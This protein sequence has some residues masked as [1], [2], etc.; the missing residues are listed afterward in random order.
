MLQLA[1]ISRN[2]LRFDLRPISVSEL[3]NQVESK[4]ASQVERAGFA[5][6]FDRTGKSGGATLQVDD[7]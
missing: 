7:D 4:I 6:Q 2:E 5:L 3:R 1:S